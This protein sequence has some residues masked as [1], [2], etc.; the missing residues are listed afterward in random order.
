MY[1]Y[2]YNFNKTN[3]CQGGIFLITQIIMNKLESLSE[4]GIRTKIINL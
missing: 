4:I 1:K 2:S 3:Y